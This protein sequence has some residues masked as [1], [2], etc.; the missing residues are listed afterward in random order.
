M[1]DLVSEAKTC[2]FPKRDCFLKHHLPRGS[3][4]LYQGSAGFLCLLSWEDLTEAAKKES[5]KKTLSFSFSLQ[6]AR[7]LN[8]TQW[9]CGRACIS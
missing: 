2:I 8:G 9:K 5:E 4:C 6:S 1:E 3:E 7:A